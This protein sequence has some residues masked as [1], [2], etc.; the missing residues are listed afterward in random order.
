MS[1]QKYGVKVDQL[2]FHS[3]A[4]L[5]GVATHPDKNDDIEEESNEDKDDA[6]KNP[7][8][9]C[10]EAGGVRWGGGED[11]GEHVDQ[12]QQGG[13]EEATA[14]GVGGWGEKET[15]GGNRHKET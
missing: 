1:N 4:S 2:I 5:I 9:E 14:G 10:G 11:R 8:G 7:G 15:H 3:G 6:G 12:D 13:E